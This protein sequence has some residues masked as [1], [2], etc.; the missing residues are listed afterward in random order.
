MFFVH[1]AIYNLIVKLLIY[2]LQKFL[3]SKKGEYGQYFHINFNSQEKSAQQKNKKQKTK[4]HWLRP[5]KDMHLRN[6]WS[7]RNFT[8]N[9]ILKY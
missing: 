9:N 5:E 1:T 3:L 8:E 7:K 2:F 4:R 6:P